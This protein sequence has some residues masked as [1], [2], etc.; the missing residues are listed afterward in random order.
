MF[1]VYCWWIDMVGVF[2]I[3]I[4]VNVFINMYIWMIF[5]KVFDN[6]VKVVFLNL[7]KM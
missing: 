1:I 4:D 5:N 2:R 7:F 6:Y 3:V